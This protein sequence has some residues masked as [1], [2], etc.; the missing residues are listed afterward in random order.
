V[1]LSRFG[2]HDS[3][4]LKTAKGNQQKLKAAQAKNKGR[5]SK[6]MSIRLSRNKRLFFS[7][8]FLIV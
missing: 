4:S 8:Q 1:E 5:G 6:V 2:G 3:G 7:L